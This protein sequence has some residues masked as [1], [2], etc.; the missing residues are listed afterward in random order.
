MDWMM[1]MN[2]LL[3]GCGLV[4]TVI[5]VVTLRSSKRKAEAEA[6]GAV[7]DTEQKNMSL[8]K[9]Y[10]DEFKENIRDPLLKE[11]KGLRRDV[12]NL[13]NAINKIND[14]PH[15]DDCPVRC[16]LQKQQESDSDEGTQRDGVES[17]AR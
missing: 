1:I 12:K 7:A 11:V 16:E 8:A 3:G 17:R 6:D 14:C 13:K 10:V 2:Y 9:D 15:I 4:S 5:S